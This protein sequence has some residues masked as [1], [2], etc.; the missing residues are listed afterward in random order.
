MTGR[1]RSSKACEFEIGELFEK[2]IKGLRHEMGGVIEN[3]ERSRNLSL[4][5]MRGLLRLSWRQW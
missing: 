1:L 2:V 5:D 4:E 3:I